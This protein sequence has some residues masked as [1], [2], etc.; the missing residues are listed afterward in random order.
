MPIE[1]V[2]GVGDS[3]SRSRSA[4]RSAADR[5]GA[6]QREHEL[7]AAHA[8]A[9]VVGADDG[10]HRVGDGAQRRVTRRVAVAV[11]DGLK[12]STSSAISASEGRRGGGVELGGRA[13]PGR[14]CG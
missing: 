7:V 3:A 2:T 12:W 1:T 11:V 6:G 13:A 4:T 14:R 10:A 5:A 9:D 8:A